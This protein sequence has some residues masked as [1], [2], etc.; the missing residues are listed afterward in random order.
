MKASGVTAI[1]FNLVSGLQKI[2][3]GLFS[4]IGYLLIKAILWVSGGS[5]N[6]LRGKWTPIK[7]PQL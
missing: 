7:I 6:C 2:W 1:V 5:G 3:R 4:I